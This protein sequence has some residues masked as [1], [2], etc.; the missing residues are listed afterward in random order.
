MVIK[1]VLIGL[2]LVALQGCGADSTTNRTLADN[3]L[4]ML[5]DVQGPVS[6][7]REGWNTYAPALFG[8]SLRYG[9]LLR[10]E[11][12]AQATVACA[13][14]TVATV[15]AGTNA[16]PCKV[17][18]AV[19]VQNGSLINPTRSVPSGEF[20]L[21]VTPRKTK[22]LNPRPTLRWTPVTG[23]TSYT[24]TVRGSNVNWSTDVI[25]G[26]EVVYPGAAPP[27]MPG[28]TYKVIVVAGNR[29]SDEEA[30]PDLGFTVLKIDEA[31]TVRE[32]ETKIRSLGLSGA[33]TGLLV[34][35]LYVTNGLTAEAI[36][37]LE[38]L[39]SASPEPAVLRSLGD[40][41]LALGLNRLA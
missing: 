13:D 35:N 27:L 20:P 34:A 29:S 24:V 2:V 5:V 15:P 14:L 40:L 33:A 37:L 30:L 26:T 32:R 10:L 7:K 21:V 1:R 11:G 28:L 25:S 22:L 4:H 31:T 16:L 8:T 39:S 18:Q 6:V 17:V 19:L 3:D 12:S 41:Y 23:A 38:G 9:D 36:E